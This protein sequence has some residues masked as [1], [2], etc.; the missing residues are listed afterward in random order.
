MRGYVV[1]QEVEPGLWRLIGDVDYQPGLAARAER[2]Q[3][4]RDATG[5]AD[6]GDGVY[7]ALHRDEWHLVSDD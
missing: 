3:A 4:V 5:G 2:G 1:L 7:A 6:P